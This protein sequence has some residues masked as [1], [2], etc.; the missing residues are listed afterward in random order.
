[1]YIIRTLHELIRCF[2]P[3]VTLPKN[4]LYLNLPILKRLDKYSSSLGVDFVVNAVRRDG[5]SYLYQITHKGNVGCI[6]IHIQRGFVYAINC[7][8]NKL[9]SI[10]EDCL[11]TDNL[12]VPPVE[13]A[14]HFAFVK[15]Q[16]D[17]AFGLQGI[18]NVNILEQEEEIS[19]IL[20]IYHTQCT[21]DYDIISR[22]VSLLDLTLDID[23]II[24]IKDDIECDQLID[25]ADD[26]IS[27]IAFDPT[28]PPPLISSSI[29]VDEEPI[30]ES[31]SNVSISEEEELYNLEKCK[32]PSG[33]KEVPKDVKEKQIELQAIRN[34]SDLSTIKEVNIV[35]P[36]LLEAEKVDGNFILSSV[37]RNA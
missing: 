22:D 26:L 30:Y 8:H 33:I 21:D 37:K 19:A 25:K 24:G 13:Q 17:E 1:M 7:T 3:N 36:L 20:P 31:I 15:N 23:S 29:A 9:E 10:I 28:I 2:K 6:P 11:S 16:I 5:S 14:I 12:V 34:K 32:K 4:E 27:V 35:S 18:E